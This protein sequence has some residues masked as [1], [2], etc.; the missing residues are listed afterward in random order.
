MLIHSIAPYFH[1]QFAPDGLRIE[2]VPFEGP[3]D[4][5]VVLIDEPFGALDA[6]TRARLQDKL[7]ALWR[8]T[9]LTVVF[10]THASE[11]ALALADRV[12]MVSPGPGRIV[13]DLRTALPRPQDVP[14]PEF[15][16]LRRELP[17]LLHLHHGRAAA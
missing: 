14:S 8:S 13:Q 6:M 1:Q 11:E 17:A 5:K 3:S 9:G 4:A 15:N 7:L 2:V 12:V 16:A 10:I